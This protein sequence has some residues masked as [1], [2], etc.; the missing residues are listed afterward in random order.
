MH[1]SYCG[2]E[3]SL[4]DACLCLPRQETGRT[5]SSE[6]RVDGPWGEASREWSMAGEWAQPRPLEAWVTA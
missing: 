2:I 1:C 3:Y 5:S 4:E 6:P